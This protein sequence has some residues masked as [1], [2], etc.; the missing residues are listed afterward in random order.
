MEQTTGSD[1][2]TTNKQT[3]IQRG[4]KNFWDLVKFALIAVIIV[5][6]IRMFKIGR[7]HV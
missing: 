2:S 1:K 7:A 5:I 6:P 4:L 3:K